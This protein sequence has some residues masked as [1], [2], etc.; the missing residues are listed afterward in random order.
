MQANDTLDKSKKPTASTGIDEQKP[1]LHEMKTKCE[2]HQ[3]QQTRKHEKHIQDPTTELRE[4]NENRSTPGQPSRPD[5][6]RPT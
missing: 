4:A 6:H 3:R 1:D 5:A 2:K